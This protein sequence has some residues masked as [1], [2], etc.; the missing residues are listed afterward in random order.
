[1]KRNNFSTNSLRQATGCA[2]VL[3]CMAAAP[4]AGAATALGKATATVLVSASVTLIAP[5]ATLAGTV[6]SLD[7]FSAS[8][9][10]SGPLLRAGTPPPPA[11]AGTSASGAAA[12]GANSASVNVTLFADGSMSISGGSGLTFAVSRP[13]EGAVNIE[14]N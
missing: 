4:G 6:P 13:S 2:L 10:A 1:M 7:S 3:A 11:T 9:S 8:L 14:Y 5:T 12:P